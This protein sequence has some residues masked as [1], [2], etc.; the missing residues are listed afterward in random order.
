LK[1]EIWNLSNGGRNDTKNE[2]K[3][4]PHVVDWFRSSHFDFSCRGPDAIF[5][6]LQLH[7]TRRTLV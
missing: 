1:K 2:R 5:S 7:L 6:S 4:F 3:I